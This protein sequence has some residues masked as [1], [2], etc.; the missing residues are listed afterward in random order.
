MATPSDVK[1]FNRLTEYQSYI[2]IIVYQRYSIQV[3]RLIRP[4]L[5]HLRHTLILHNGK[6]L[7]TQWQNTSYSTKNELSN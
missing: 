1:H 6:Y 3:F 2:I 7:L 4:I 5:Q